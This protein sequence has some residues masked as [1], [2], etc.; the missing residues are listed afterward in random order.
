MTK[1][2]F[3]I[4]GG[5]IAHHH[6]NPAPM[7]PLD[8]QL[9]AKLREMF[10]RPLQPIPPFGDTYKRI[11]SRKLKKPYDEVTRD[12]RDAVKATTWALR[13]IRDGDETLKALY[14]ADLFDDDWKDTPRV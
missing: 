1:R 12:E 3:G 13:Y 9:M 11:A 8:P 4:V 7:P 10:L 6:P 2:P 14:G 5:R